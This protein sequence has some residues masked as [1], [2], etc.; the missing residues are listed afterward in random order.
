MIQIELLNTVFDCLCF[1]K[2]F[3]GLQYTIEIQ[4]KCNKK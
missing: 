2:A 1:R 4:Y 3:D